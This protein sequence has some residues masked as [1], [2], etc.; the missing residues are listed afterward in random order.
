PYAEYGLAK[1]RSGDA[2]AYVSSAGVRSVAD[3]DAGNFRLALG[4]EAL[5]ANVNPTGDA[6][7]DTFGSLET[8][9]EARH[10]MGFSVKGRAVP[11]GLAGPV[12]SSWHPPD[13]PRRAA[14]P[15]AFEAQYEGGVTFGTRAP[16][17]LWGMGLPRIGF[18]Y[19]FAQN[20]SVFRL[21]IGIPAPSLR[22]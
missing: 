18:G 15:L 21:V 1:D 10:D 8:C 11:Y 6:D 12:S 4:N 22:R 13:S 14:G 5:V 20:L 2:S 19:R 16:A 3:F 9:L 7:S 17:K